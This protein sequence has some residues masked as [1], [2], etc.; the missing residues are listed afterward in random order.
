M[1]EQ[2]LDQSSLIKEIAGEND[3]SVSCSAFEVCNIVDAKNSILV[4]PIIMDA[5]VLFIVL[6]RVSFRVRR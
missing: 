1:M 2:A 5:G 4:C 3:W 6:T